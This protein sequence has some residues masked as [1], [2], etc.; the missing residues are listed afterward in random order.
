MLS[1]DGDVSSTFLRNSH[2][3][4]KSFTLRAPLLCEINSNGFQQRA[5]NPSR[6]ARTP[7]HAEPS[8]P[9]IPLRPRNL[10]VHN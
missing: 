7:A 3:S 2:Y 1:R 10:L 4:R 9:L 5:N 6:A 8:P